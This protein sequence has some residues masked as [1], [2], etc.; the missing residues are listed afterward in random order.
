MLD[1]K[2][3]WQVRVGPWNEGDSARN[4][5]KSLDSPT[6]FKTTLGFPHGYKLINTLLSETLLEFRVF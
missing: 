1:I 5:A 4:I 3:N 6:N 2:K